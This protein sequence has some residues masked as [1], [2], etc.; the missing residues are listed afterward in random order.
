MLVVM[1]F[2]GSSVA[3]LDKIRNVAERCIKKWKEGNQV[4]VVLSAM[5]KTTDRLLAQAGEIS[6]MPSR[7][8]MDMLLATG[9]QVSVS[10]MAMTMIQMGVTAIS[11][12]AWQ[13][14]MH[15]TSAYQN[16]KLKRIDSE[17]I[18]KELD[19]NKI[20]VVTGFQGINKYDDVTTLGRGGSDTTAVALAAALNA[21]LC[22]I[23]TDV[24]GVY[25]ADPRIVPKARKMPEVTYEEMLEFA[26]LG[27]K[28]LHSR[29]VEMA[30][31]YDV[32]LVVRSSM[33]EEEGTV[34]KETTKMEK[35]LIS[36]V[37][38]DKNIAK[39]AVSGMKDN[40]ES[41]FKLLNLMAKNGVNID[42]MIQSLEKDGTKTLTF[43]VARPDMMMTLDLLKKYSDVIG[44]AN[45]SCEED[46]AKVSV[47]GAGVSS[48]P[49]VAAKMFEALSNAGINTDM[50]TTSEIRITA[51][52][53]ES[54][55]E[56]A[57]R[58]VHDRFASE[59][60]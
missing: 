13:V 52:I 38:V 55:A 9:E 46:V 54:E 1:K 14:P 44:N 34:V 16:A 22:E 60:D 43:T 33:S 10:L 50:V 48:N 35:M 2:G 4:V 19:S 40:P 8:E 49:G 5:G 47:V 21:D 51:V 41:T 24:D 20:V 36:G 59:W 17:R 11:L 45:V 32:N 18:T 53:K 37:A 56:T 39:I 27:A 6:S 7:R 28:V 15:T 23:Y 42:V 31:R 3:D 12:N 58:A 25:T 26:S 57:M 30:R 29:C